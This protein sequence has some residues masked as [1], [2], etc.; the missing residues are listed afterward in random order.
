MPTRRSVIGQFS[1]A[2]LVSALPAGA[3]NTDTLPL[4]ISVTTPPLMVAPVGVFFEAVLDEP[5]RSTRRGAN[6]FPDAYLPEF[7]EITYIW[8]L[9]DVG[10]ISTPEHLIAEHRRSDRAFGPFIA[11]VFETPGRHRIAVE[12][13]SPDGRHGRAE[14]FIDV[15]DPA[16]TFGPAGTI[17]VSAD[18]DF[19]GAPPHDPRNALPDLESAF[20]R[21]QQLGLAQVQILLRR[22][23]VHVP[24]KGKSLRFRDQRGHCHL[25]A[26]GAGARPMVD[27]SHSG[28]GLLLVHPKWDGHALV[29][30]DLHIRGGWDPMVELWDGPAH[31]AVISP[32]GDAAVLLHNC[33]EERC[34]VTVNSRPPKTSTGIRAMTFINAYE[35]TDFKDFLLLGPRDHVDVAVTGCRV[36]QNRMALNGGENRAVTSYSRYGRNSHSFV[37]CSASRL[38]IASNDI[39]IRHGWAQQKVIDNPA[40]RINRNNVPN[41]RAIVARNHI[42]GMI[43]RGAKATAVPLNLLIEQ[44]YVVANPTTG[45]AIELRGGSVS[46]RNNIILEHAT[47]KARGTGRGFQNFL[48]LRWR[49]KPNHVTQDMPFFV[50]NNSFILLRGQ[51]PK[52]FTL[53]ENEKGGFSQIQSGNNLLWAPKFATDP[54]GDGPLDTTSLGWDARYPGFRIGWARLKKQALPQHLFPGDTFV[55]PYWTDFLGFPLSRADFE[56]EA[57]RHALIIHASDG[58][59]S[60]DALSGEVQV[61]FEDEGVR[62]AYLGSEHWRA[63]ATFSLHCDRGRTPSALQTDFAQPPGTLA[64]YTPLE[65]A[66]AWQSATPDLLASYDFL[67]RVRPGTGLFAAPQG[68]PSRGA[69]EP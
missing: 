26:W 34:S 30:R 32:R 40:F 56:G 37:R 68:R 22:N 45:P 55:V 6:T 25:G 41:M 9:P 24:P 51:M 67:G 23:Q 10:P 2:T 20:A 5:V 8:S 42:E 12:A 49:G 18:L 28:A 53:I 27:M 66:G 33:F 61:S 52:N 4:S 36:V 39:F 21:Y 46:V 3:Q 11:R 62:V 1:A 7:H 47:P 13:F 16:N 15:A 54:T 59:R 50:H 44:N 69:V 64:L 31:G 57:G 48:S 58:N 63:G 17:V 65:G 19:T 14:V 38:Y 43:V 29:M 35:K 60:Y